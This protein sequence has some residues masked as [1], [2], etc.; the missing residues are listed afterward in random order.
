[1][2]VPAFAQPGGLAPGE[3]ITEHGWGVLSIQPAEKGALH[4]SIEAVGGNLF[5]CGLDGE[6]RN[7]RAV[8]PGDGKRCIVQFTR[9][10]E[11]I[12]VAADPSCKYHCGARAVLEP[13]VKDCRRTLD[14]FQGGWIRNDL[15]ITQYR[16]GDVAGCRHTLAPL[17]KD[18]R[19][20]D[21]DLKQEYGQMDAEKY[22]PVIRAAR[23]N[24]K[25]C[26][27]KAAGR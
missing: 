23:T 17:Q 24:L 27:G 10:G 26:G 19:Q 4:F 13:L 15:A 3:Y 12:D 21:E 2:P 20:S 11:D 8:L 1:M 16:L 14:R 25:L 22:L 7:G 6:I 9:K 18:A 5:V